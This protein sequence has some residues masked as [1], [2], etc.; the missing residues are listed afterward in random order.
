MSNRDLL[1]QVIGLMLVVLLLAGCGPRIEPGA[2]LSGQDLSGRDLRGYANLNEV[3]LSESNLEKVNLSGVNLS[4]ANLSGA[5][6]SN[7]YLGGAD[8]SG[9]DLSG[10]N[11]SDEDYLGGADLS[12]ADLSEAD[13]SEANLSEADL[14]GANLSGANLSEADLSEAG[15]SGAD[16]KGAD[17]SEADLSES[18][19]NGAN[20]SEADLSKADLSE[21]NMNGVDL[22]GAKLFR[23]RLLGADGVTDEILEHTNGG[24]IWLSAVQ[25]GMTRICQGEGIPQAANYIDEADSHPTIILTFSD[26][27]FYWD[28]LSRL[29]GYDID[30]YKQRLPDDLYP[31]EISD[32]QLVACVSRGWKSIETCRYSGGSYGGDC[33]LNR[34]IYKV[35]ISLIEAKTGNMIATET[36]VG[37]NPKRCPQTTAGCLSL[38]GDEV[39]DLQIKIMDWLETYV[40]ATEWKF[41]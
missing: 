1:G 13:L 2:D 10:A 35:N 24:S 14:S 21:A 7:A 9:A 22:S 40:G 12:E 27:E 36:L 6:L 32:A 39:E 4:R 17:L 25:D 29:H 31:A 41:D 34:Y 33:T 15:L 37:G 30:T 23:V 26:D 11:L 5:N 19:L 16:L 38:Y 3:N 18:N 28:S 8:L 20:L